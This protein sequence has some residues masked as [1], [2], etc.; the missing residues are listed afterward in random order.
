MYSIINNLY[1][2]SYSDYSKIIVYVKLKFI[3]KFQIV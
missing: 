1:N 2:N 3:F